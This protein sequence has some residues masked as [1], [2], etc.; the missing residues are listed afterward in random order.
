MLNDILAHFH[1]QI[2]LPN[3]VVLNLFLLR[4]RLEDGKRPCP[5]I[6]YQPIIIGEATNKGS[7]LYI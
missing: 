1:F 3:P 5:G 7:M 4:L 6:F 2:S